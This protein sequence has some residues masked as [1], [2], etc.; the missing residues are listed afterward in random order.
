LPGLDHG[1]QPEVLEFR[2]P[3]RPD[4]LA[5]RARPICRLRACTKERGTAVPVSRE[6]EDRDFRDTS[7]WESLNRVGLLPEWLVRRTQSVYGFSAESRVCASASSDNCSVG[8][9]PPTA[10]A[11]TAWASASRP[12]LR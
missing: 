10:G 1:D 11:S 9:K 2:K 4:R 12:V 7:V 6:F 5:I 3:G 8:G